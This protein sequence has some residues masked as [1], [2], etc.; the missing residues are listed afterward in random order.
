MKAKAIFLAFFLLATLGLPTIASEGGNIGDYAPEFPEGEF[1]DAGQYKLKDYL[2]KVVVLFFYEKRCPSCKATIPSRNKIVGRFQNSPVKFFG[3]AAGDSIQEA[4]TYV[5][6]THLNMP[7]FADQQS[8]MEKAYG[9]DISMQNVYQVRLIGPDG[10]IRD[11]DMKVRS[12]EGVLRELET[13]PG[14]GNGLVQS[15]NEAAKRGGK[16]VSQILRK[17][18]INANNQAISLLN[19]ANYRAAIA[20]FEAVLESDPDY[21]S[22][23]ENLQVA[24]TNYGV[25]L[26]QNDSPEAEEILRKAYE[27]ALKYFPD[28]KSR[29]SSAMTN[30]ANY[31][32]GKGRSDEA[33]Q[34]RNS[35]RGGF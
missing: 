20:A 5:A 9:I 11:Y 31:L 6:E 35:V 25:E 7:V 33:A 28:D 23:R 34:L 24:Y 32:D 26:A 12:I 19:K 8:L 16:G 13:A 4:R 15:A 3:I 21:Q 14:N 30:Y 10:I 17:K 1:T 29:L 27:I 2:G 18:S 22:A